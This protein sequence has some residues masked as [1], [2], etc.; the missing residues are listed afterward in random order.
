MVGEGDVVEVVVGVVGVEGGPA[1][2]LALQ[3]DDPLA[4][5]GRWPRRSPRA[6]SAPPG[7]VHGH[8]HHGGVVEVG[9]VGVAVL[10]GPA[11]GAHV[12][13]RARPSRPST[14]STCSGFSQ[15]S[16]ARGRRLGLA[17]PASIRA[18][19]GE[20]RVPHRRDAGLAVGLVVLD[21]QQLLDRLRGRWRGADGPADSRARRTSSRCWPWPDRWRPGHPRRSA[22]RSTKSRQRSMAR[23][24]KRLRPDRL[25]RL[26]HGV[27]RVEDHRPD[28]LRCRAPSAAR[29]LGRRPAKSS[30]T[31][32]AARIARARL[33]RLQHQQRH[34]H[35]ARPVGH[36]GQV[37]REP[38]RQQ[39]ISAGMAG[40][41]A[42]GR[43]R[44]TAPAGC[45]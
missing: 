34:D 11:A 2:V 16:A 36:L 4:R 43:L 23:W 32:I 12:G 19:R 1:A 37:D 20:R 35:R 9:I 40:D 30:A 33:Q 8:G 41:C 10:E 45:G 22:A 17:P 18:W 24:R 39:I 44:R 21:H 7:A 42:P 15:S 31:P 26:E 28:A 5:R 38:P 3:A 13:T 25:D 29:R 6:P 14:S 27:E